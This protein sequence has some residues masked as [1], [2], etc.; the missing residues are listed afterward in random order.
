M[1]LLSIM[2]WWN[3]TSGAAPRP[4]KQLNRTT[5]SARDVAADDLKRALPAKVSCWQGGYM[6]ADVEAALVERGITLE[7]LTIWTG[8]A[9]DRYRL[10]VEDRRRE[11]H[12]RGNKPRGKQR[13]T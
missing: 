9:A 6:P 12:L 11:W 10:L 8:P 13:K 3:H 2:V 5:R 7:L 1:H 4:P